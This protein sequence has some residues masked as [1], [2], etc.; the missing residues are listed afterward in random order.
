[1]LF[2]NR[3]EWRVGESSLG[4]SNG[5]GGQKILLNFNFLEKL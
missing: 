5:T 4:F 3:V 2:L 1:M